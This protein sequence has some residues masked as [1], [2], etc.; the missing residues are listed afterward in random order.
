MAIARSRQASTYS[1][2]H[3]LVFRFMRQHVGVQGQCGGAEVRGMVADHVVVALEVGDHLCVGVLAVP[4]LEA[5]LDFDRVAGPVEA[6]GVAEERAA[7]AVDETL[8]DLVLGI[9]V[10]GAGVFVHVE[11]GIAADAGPEGRV[12]GIAQPHQV[13]D[14]EALAVVE[15]VEHDGELL[16]VHPVARHRD[17]DGLRAGVLAKVP[18]PTFRVQPPDRIG[19]AEGVED[20]P[21][22]QVLDGV[23]RPVVASPALDAFEPAAVVEVAVEEDLACLCVRLDQ[24]PLEQCPRRW[25]QRST[26]LDRSVMSIC[27]RPERD[28][29]RAGATSSGC[30]VS[31][32][33]P[34]DVPWALFQGSML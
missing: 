26:D 12:I 20:R 11:P 4:G 10:R 7:A 6:G 13:E 25:R 5:V 24:L 22:G 31:C 16:V 3:F 9:V 30:H 8:D 29:E 15:P 2:S 23:V 14:R 27:R 34:S 19:T 33:S 1:R 21:V 17:I 32:D 28:Q 18:L